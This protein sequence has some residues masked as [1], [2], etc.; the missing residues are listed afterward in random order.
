LISRT[1][2]CLTPRC[3]SHPLIKHFSV[4]TTYRT[5]TGQI[6]SDDDAI[7]PLHLA[8]SNNLERVTVHALA[9]VYDAALSSTYE[10][11]Y[12][13]SL[14]AIA[15]FFESPASSKHITLNFRISIYGLTPLSDL[16][17]SALGLDSSSSMLQHINLRVSA[18]AKV[19]RPGFAK[20]V[21]PATI[22]SS[23]SRNRHLKGLVEKGFLTIEPHIYA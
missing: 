10:A 13:W 15:R 23:L 6:I 14:P 4:Q 7:V 9:T 3:F 8:G 1:I 22:L 18:T 20:A 17:W 21:P 5:L 16:N 2:V 19:T 12:S 11:H